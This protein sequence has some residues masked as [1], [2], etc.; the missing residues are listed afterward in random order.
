MGQHDPLDGLVT[1][2]ELQA[3][4]LGFEPGSTGPDL[5]PEVAEMTDLCRGETW[6]TDDPLGIGGV[7][8]DAG[9]VAQLT[10]LAAG[11]PKHLLGTLL[12]AAHSG[13]AAWIRSDPLGAPAED[14]IPFREL[15]LSIGW[16]AVAQWGSTMGKRAEALLW[17]AG[18]VERIEKFW[19][20]EESRKAA[21]WTAHADINTV[22]LAT[23]LAP[24][25]FL[26]V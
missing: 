25:E 2:Q 23:A 8:F 7:L 13:L 1:Y 18:P 20:D 16:R 10:G 24:D 21:T 17:Y 11:E 12:D 22:M 26:T 15:G 6:V 9:R 19:K 14:R 3:C 4:A 5:G